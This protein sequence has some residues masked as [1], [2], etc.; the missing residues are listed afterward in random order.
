MST[1]SEPGPAPGPRPAAPA[2]PRPTPPR[3]QRLAEA[4]EAGAG[5]SERLSAL[6]GEPLE[7]RAEG[8]AELAEDL[9]SALR[10]AEG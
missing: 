4:S 3:E 2:L 8:L 7:T 5:A 6:A 1:E 9:R 10:L